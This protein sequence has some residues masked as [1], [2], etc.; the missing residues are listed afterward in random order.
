[1]AIFKVRQQ[2]LFILF[3]HQLFSTAMAQ[4]GLSHLLE[5]ALKWGA[6]NISQFCYSHI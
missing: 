1:M 3:R 5:Q 2:H 6:N 4:A